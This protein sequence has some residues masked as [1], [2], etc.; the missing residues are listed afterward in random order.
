MT[1]RLIYNNCVCFFYKKYGATK[2]NIKY[3]FFR[4]INVV[5][6]ILIKF[7]E[8]NFIL[9]YFSKNKLFDIKYN[10]SSNA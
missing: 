8:N 7:L 10:F 1:L 9:R 5:F 4:L 2:L 6:A 3:L